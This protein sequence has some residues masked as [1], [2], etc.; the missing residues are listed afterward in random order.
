MLFASSIP[1]SP[2]QYLF[3]INSTA[4]FLSFSLLS[5]LIFFGIGF[6]F[7]GDRV[8]LVFILGLVSYSIVEILL[9]STGK[10]RSLT[11]VIDSNLQV[12]REIL[13][14]IGITIFFTILTHLVFPYAS[15]GWL[16]A[17]FLI[18]FLTNSYITHRIAVQL[19]GIINTKPKIKWRRIAALPL[20]I[21][22]LVF[23]GFFIKYYAP[24]QIG[25]TEEKTYGNAWAYFASAKA[26]SNTGVFFAVPVGESSE[27]PAGYS[28]FEQMNSSDDPGYIFLQAIAHRTGLELDTKTNLFINRSLYIFGSVLFAFAVAILVFKSPVAFLAIG[29]ALFVSHEALAPVMYQLADHHGA[30]IGLSLIGLSLLVVLPILTRSTSFTAII[31]SVFVI[32]M[33]I[34]FIGSIR[35]STGMTLLFSALSLLAVSWLISAKK[36]LLVIIPVLLA[37]IIGYKTVNDLIGILFVYRDSQTN[38]QIA[39]E[40]PGS[41][42]IYFSLLG[43]VTV[44]NDAIILKTI[45]DENPLVMPTFTTIPVGEGT[46]TYSTFNPQVFKVSQQLFLREV[47]K[48]PRKFI[49]TN[50]RDAAEIIRLLLTYASRDWLKGVV[51]LILAFGAGT[52][53]ESIWK[54]FCGYSTKAVDYKPLD[55]A[56]VAVL[57]FFVISAIIP[58][59][60]HINLQFLQETMASFIVLL[61]LVVAKYLVLTRQYGERDQP[62]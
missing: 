7:P 47:A 44:W 45:A 55:S 9:L 5:V 43:G 14:L 21:V 6:F 3:W 40:T 31:I 24:M 10:I 38:I 2:R 20:W 18:L 15:L 25:P 12:G 33:A 42:G 52:S 49:G 29:G 46:K 62:A 57:V 34:S 19:T 37:L 30:V 22:S 1:A 28:R 16:F 23:L 32:G 56:I 27:Y 17:M 13:L 36:R 58:V 11:R 8:R 61:L 26:Y 50:L 35:Q 53:L 39:P 59:M 60:T 51:F 54:Q 41:H 48:N 4:A